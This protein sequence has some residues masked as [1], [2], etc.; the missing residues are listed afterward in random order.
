MPRLTTEHT[1]SGEFKESEST[2]QKAGEQQTST[3][4]D[5]R[6]YRAM[7]CRLFLNKMKF[8][9]FKKS[10]ACFC[11]TQQRVTGGLKSCSMLIVDLAYEYHEG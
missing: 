6:D 11:P 3:A 10:F 8:Q 7:I 5:T 9:T 1:V 4:A 2:T